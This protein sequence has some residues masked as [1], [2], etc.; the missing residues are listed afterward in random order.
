V[1]QASVILLS[2]MAVGTRYVK[3]EQVNAMI[4][5]E[6]NTLHKKI[7]ALY[8]GLDGSLDLGGSSAIQEDGNGGKGWREARECAITLGQ[9]ATLRWILHAK[10]LGVSK[11]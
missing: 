11:T 5:V 4:H 2:K 9:E 1:Y 7:V 10:P 6:K 8:D 3:R